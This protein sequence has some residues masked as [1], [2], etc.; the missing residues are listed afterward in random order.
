MSGEVREG[1][2]VPIATQGKGPGG[3]AKRCWSLRIWLGDTSWGS[4]AGT[5]VRSTFHGWTEK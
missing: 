5:L 3:P 2:N 1:V 4:V